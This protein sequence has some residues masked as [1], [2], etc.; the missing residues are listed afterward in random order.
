MFASSASTCTVSVQATVC[1]FP[2]ARRKSGTAASSACSERIASGSR[3]ASPGS[4]GGATSG[5]SGCG[6]ESSARVSGLSALTKIAFGLSWGRCSA[7][8]RGRTPSSRPG[9]PSPLPCTSC[10]QRPPGRRTSSARSTRWPCASS[11]SSASRRVI[12]AQEAGGEVREDPGLGEDQE[13]GVVRHHLEPPELLLRLPA[14]PPVAGSALEGA[15]LPRR[16]TQPPAPEGRDV[17]QAAARQPAEAEI[18]VRV[19]QRVPQRTLLRRRQTDLDPGQG[20]P[21]GRLPVH[22]AGVHALANRHAGSMAHPA[23]ERQRKPP[24]PHPRACHAWS[25]NVKRN[26]A[27]S[28]IPAGSASIPEMAPI[29]RPRGWNGAEIAPWNGLSGR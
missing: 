5:G 10:R 3:E 9:P 16:Q 11:Q 18:V 14:G 19:H 29:G 22:R 27:Q 6:L 26:Q 20:I 1:F 21:F 8:W 2:C 25:P 15:V 7:R 4:A 28:A 12:P 13:P 23:R 17:A 24:A